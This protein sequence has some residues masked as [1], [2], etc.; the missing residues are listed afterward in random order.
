[1][2]LE[3]FSS[4]YRATGPEVALNA[5]AAQ[6]F[7]LLVHELATNAAKHDALSNPG[8]RIGIEWSVE[9]ANG[10][11]RLKFRWLERGDPVVAPPNREGFGSGLNEKVVAQEF[12]AIPQINF[13]PEGLSYEID[14]PLWVVVANY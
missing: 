6:A 9:S 10:K 8:S 2:E 1:M 12:C 13:E 3:P 5:K 11:A 7:A 14:A 4:R